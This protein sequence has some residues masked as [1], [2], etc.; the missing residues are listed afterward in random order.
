MEETYNRVL[1]SSMLVLG[2]F[3][4]VVP[5]VEHENF[6]EF[7]KQ[8]VTDGKFWRHAKN[9]VQQVLLLSF[10]P[11]YYLLYKKWYF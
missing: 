5:Q 4:D 10:P 6:I 3:L 8:I 11:N 2:F 9:E 1:S 7:Y